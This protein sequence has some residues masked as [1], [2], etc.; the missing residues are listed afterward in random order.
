MAKLIPLYSS[1]SGNS[2]YISF[3]EG[4][5]LVDCGTNAKRILTALNEREIDPATI[6][7]LFITHSHN[8]HVSA[9]SVLNKKLKPSK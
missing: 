3:N 4:A 2:V 5:V 7:A 1:S 8:D 9:L 6:K